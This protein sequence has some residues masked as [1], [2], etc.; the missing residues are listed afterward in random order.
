MQV[1]KSLECECEAKN[2]CFIDHRNISPKHNCNRNGLNLN[3]LELRNL[4]KNV[5]F[6]YINLIA[7]HR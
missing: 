5:F 2:I 7:K 1:N 6:T 4:W 3:I